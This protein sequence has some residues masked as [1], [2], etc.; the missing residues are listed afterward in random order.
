MISIA[1]LT[2]NTI[3]ILFISRRE[4]RDV[5]NCIHSVYAVQKMHIMF[6]N[7]LKSTITKAVVVVVLVVVA[8]SGESEGGEEGEL[9]GRHLPAF[10]RIIISFS[11]ELE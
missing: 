10:S 8:V 3:R 5:G 4:C 11:S 2:L 6:A 1:A 9:G 7:L